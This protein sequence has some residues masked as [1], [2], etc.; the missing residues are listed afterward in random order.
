LYSGRVPRLSVLKRQA[1]SSLLKLSALIWSS[2]EYLVPPRSPVYCGHSPFLVEGADFPFLVPD[3]PDTP[4][5][6]HTSPTMSKT[7]AGTERYGIRYMV[8][9]RFV[10]DNDYHLFV[11]SSTLSL[12]LAT[13]FPDLASL[14]ARVL[15]RRISA[16][17]FP[18]MSPTYR[19]CLSN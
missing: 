2:G 11:H 4:I 16:I 1:T 19:C 14:Q 12:N 9:L 17:A 10:M 13:P 18:H 7:N 6:T 8:H 3:W 15:C 5:V